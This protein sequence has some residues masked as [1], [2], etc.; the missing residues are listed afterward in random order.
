MIM[1]DHD[2]SN[3]DR[4]S[5]QWCFFTMTNNNS[6]VGGFN[7]SEKYEFVSWDHYSQY[8]ESHKIHVPDHQPVRSTQPAAAPDPIA[9]L[10]G[11][12][13]G[14]LACHSTADDGDMVDMMAATQMAV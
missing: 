14:A 7:P 2:Y 13:G 5:H 3:N 9:L 4:W 11:D 6:L 1:H 12:P 10:I 8:M